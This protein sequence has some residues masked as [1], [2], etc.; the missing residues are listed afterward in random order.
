[1]TSLNEA[2]QQFD[3]TSA[4]VAPR[5]TAGQSGSILTASLSY[6]RAR[7]RFDRLERLSKLPDRTPQ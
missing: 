7:S 1:M 2:R 3:S 6:E 5:S 4:A